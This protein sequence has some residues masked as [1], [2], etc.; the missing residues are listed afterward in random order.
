MT[1]TERTVTDPDEFWLDQSK[2]LD[3]DKAPSVAGEWS[4]AADDLS[5]RWFSDGVLNASVQCLDR[6][7]AGHG[8]RTAI[9][10]EGDEPGTSQA[11]SY[12]RAHEEVCR[13]ANVLKARA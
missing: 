11:I 7:L 3:W 5:I 2:R 8:D 13:M 9:L 6:H 1:R 12:A 10:W 4:W